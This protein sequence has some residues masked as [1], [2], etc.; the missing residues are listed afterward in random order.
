MALQK[1]QQTDEGGS[2]FGTLYVVAT[3]IGHYDDLSLRAL[4]ILSQVDLIASENPM[5]TQALL[6]HHGV[7]ATITSYGPLNRRMKAAV[8]L[9][10]LRTGTTVALLS[11]EGTPLVYD[12][13]TLLVRA[14]LDAGLAV[15][16]V[17]GPSVVT[18]ALSV[19][20]MACDS[21]RFEGMLPS[22]TAAVRSLFSKLK[23]DAATSV[24]FLDPPR[25]WAV[26]EVLASMLPRRPI[27]I[28]CDLTTTHEKVL[29]GLPRLVLSQRK[30]VGRPQT[31]T[32]MIEGASGNARAIHRRK[33]GFTRR[34]GGE[35]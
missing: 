4:R 23:R 24:F 25:L 21:F 8:L 29:R 16:S 31:V 28:A 34:R 33:T 12:P 26:V 17:P 15:V 13:G 22:T 7:A 18:A 27:A 6:Q 9:H 3:P 20:G 30:A 35:S 1:S 10:K 32:L 19:S 11:D 14:A 5:A 2:V